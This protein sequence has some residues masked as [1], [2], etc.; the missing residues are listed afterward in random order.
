MFSQKTFN[1]QNNLE[2]KEQHWKI[3]DVKMHHGVT[4]VKACV[5]HLLKLR[6]LSWIFLVVD[7]IVSGTN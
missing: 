3:L 5:T 7:L 4:E 2:E 1:T 6:R